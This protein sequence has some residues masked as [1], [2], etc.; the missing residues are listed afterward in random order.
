M[1]ACTMPRVS[2]RNPACDGSDEEPEK[3]QKRQPKKV[4]LRAAKH[5]STKRPATTKTV[6]AKGNEIEI[7][8]TP[9]KRGKQIVFS[10][11]TR[12][13]SR[14][15]TS[16]SQ[17]DESAKLPPKRLGTLL[18]IEDTS[19][20]ES[21]RKRKDPPNT[22]A[23]VYD[24][25]DGALSKEQGRPGDGIV[26]DTPMAAAASTLLYQLQYGGHDSPDRSGHDSPDRLE[27]SN[28]KKGSHSTNTLDLGASSSSDKDMD[29][30][31]DG[32]VFSDDE[33]Y[34]LDIDYD[35]E[36]ERLRSSFPKNKKRM[37]II[38]GGPQPPDL[39]MYPESEH[40]AVLDAYI[41]VRK[42]FTDKDRHA[43][44]KKM[45]S[46]AK[47]S[48]T[49]VKGDQ[50]EQL[51]P[52]SVVEGNRLVDGDTF[53][54]KNV[55]QL[56]ISE[57]ANLRGITTRANRSDLM[58]LTV[59]GVKFYVNAT[60]HEHTGWVVHS[61]VCRE[62]DDVLQIPPKDRIELSEME[63]KKGKMR[64]PIGA[65]S[66]VP[67]I[68]DAVSDN[69][70][71]TYQSI[72]EIMKPYAKEYTLTDS[73]VQ[74]ARDRAKLELFGSAEENVR[75]ARGVM[76]HVRQL[77]HEVEMIFQDRQKTLQA[78][79]LV[80][81]HED[82]LRRKKMKLPALDKASQLQYVNKWKAENELHLNTEFGYKDGPQFTFL[83]GV[84]F[85]TSSSKHLVPLL[86]NVV[87]ADGAHS[88]FGKYTLFSAYA[89]T[90]NGNMS[91]L[92]FGLLFGNEDTNNW[93]KFWKFVKQVHPCIDSPAV[94][95]L[96]DQ[97]KGSIV[98]VGKEVKQ[99]AQFHC[100]FHRRQNIIKTLGGGK[101][102]TPLTALWL[103]NLLCGCHSVAQLEKN[104]ATYYPQMHP[105]ALH[106]LTKLQDK[107]Q[108][109]AARCAMGENI[110][111]FNK[112][113]SSGVESM[114]RANNLARQRT[115][116]DILNAL[117][118]L[119][120]LE[121]TRFNHYKQKA[122]E[123][124]EI[125]TCR[126]QDLMEEAFRD[127]N[128][129]EYRISMNKCDTFHR[130]TVSRMT[131]TNE[132]T[133]IIPVEETMG[134]R[135]GTCTC[136]KPKTDGVPCRHM[137]VVA[138]SSKIEGLTRIQIM[139]YWWT[140]AH[141]RAQYAMDVYCKT[142]IS[143]NT[144]KSMT[145]PEDRLR[146]CPSWTAAKKKGRP[147]ADNREKSLVDHIA[148]SAKKKR[149]SRRTKLYCRI[150]HKFDHNMVDCFQNPGNQQST[151]KEATDDVG[152]EGQEGN[153]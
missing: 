82:L 16:A 4:P 76:D 128:L 46:E 106:Y 58:N 144:V 112:S 25:L 54:N 125:L 133:V 5:T 94:T 19:I 150:C 110:C 85:A 49:T 105:A 87:Q 88:S 20:V 109:P 130:I 10:P 28:G 71:V 38:P 30:K 148:D 56:R 126:G 84:L 91:P 143:L 117:I 2:R 52:M 115:A 89:T 36:E 116:V 80:V 151:L 47:L 45:N 8:G 79:G 35:S 149:G 131:S 48:A 152:E 134:S 7:A 145:V 40:E 111:M 67:I 140:T 26:V 99:A 139:P 127:V 3:P 114:N 142:D 33:D 21:L 68:K 73:V 43:R 12:K 39:T 77:G 147:K 62:G 95:I 55:L 120:K 123:R 103:Y 113:A 64:I 63:T 51:R 22:R 60:F 136:G 57:E 135:F 65:K 42:K 86:Q 69:P 37:N 138:M 50:N 118:L 18:A 153:V 137:V 124:D 98:A 93:S 11:K 107:C 101:G 15:G 119:I 75:Y 34:L 132:Y 81:L 97:D 70:G 122:W 32:L 29:Y 17:D 59:V 96:T 13:S 104:K 61:A 27:A 141:W 31:P 1:T 74:D 14:L 90:A 100:S 72:R 129:M 9:N 78:A 108:Y 92:A 23:S 24:A 53:K 44:V 102:S 66:L 121:G 146:Y 6:N 83:T 41:A